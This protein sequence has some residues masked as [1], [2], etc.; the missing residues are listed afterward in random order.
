MLLVLGDLGD[1][2]HVSQ[3]IELHDIIFLKP[4][5]II[6]ALEKTLDL[7]R[8]KLSLEERVALLRSHKYTFST[9]LSTNPN[10]GKNLPH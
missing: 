9:L 2:L 1:V 5:K 10:L 7:E 3:N 6:S 8:V 4:A